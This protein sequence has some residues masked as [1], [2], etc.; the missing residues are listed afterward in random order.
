MR[1]IVLT[2]L[3]CL[4]AI[5]SM[6]AQKKLTGVVTDAN[7]KPIPG[8][9]VLIKGTEKGTVTDM[10]GKY[11]IEVTKGETLSF[12]MF[13]MNDVLK[14]VGKTNKIHVVL[15]EDGSNFLR[16]GVEY[17]KILLYNRYGK[18]VFEQDGFKVKKKKELLLHI[19]K[20]EIFE[21]LKAGTYFYVLQDESSKHADIGYITKKGSGSI[22]LDNYDNNK[23]INK[24]KNKIIVK[25]KNKMNNPLIVVDGAVKSLDYELNEISPDTIESMSILKGEAATNKYGSKAKNGVVLIITKKDK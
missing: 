3:A 13:G 18:K 6:M 22:I 14:T 17:K 9:L 10:E 21:E 23:F 12:S 24:K 5:C 4:V 16:G 7:N 20:E 2:V 19:Q 8:V 1:Q 11:E 15:E 25:G